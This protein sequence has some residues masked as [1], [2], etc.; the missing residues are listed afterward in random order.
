[1][2]RCE[3][4]FAAEDV[5]AAGTFAGYGSVFGNT[6]AYGDVVVRG[7][8]GKSL[9]AWKKDGVYPPMLLQHGFAM[10][11]LPVGKWTLMREDEQGLYVEGRVINLD[12]EAG[13][14]I[15][16]GLKEGVLNGL[17]IGYLPREFA[18]GNGVTE[19]RR[20]LKA[21]DLVEVSIVTMP[22][23][24]LARIASVKSLDDMSAEDFRDIEAILRTKGLSQTDAKKAISGFKDWLRRDAGGAGTTAR[25]GQDSAITD[26]ARFMREYLGA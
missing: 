19:P 6:D 3:V 9:A 18:S 15:H 14:S 24:K 2:E 11:G 4:K 17:S 5:T 20:T 12:T 22:A 1:M 16:G 13:K 25:D 26:L 21:V 8:F 23:N 10:D 7:A